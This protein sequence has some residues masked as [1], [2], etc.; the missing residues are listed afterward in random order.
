MAKNHVKKAFLGIAFALSMA[1]T[2]VPLPIKKIGSN[3]P[4]HWPVPAGRARF[5]FLCPNRLKGEHL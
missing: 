2:E 4:C 5:S 1:S 3:G